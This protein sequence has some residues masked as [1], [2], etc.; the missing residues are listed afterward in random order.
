M[1]MGID[2]V[3]TAAATGIS[4]T[5]TCVKTIQSYRKEGKSLNIERRCS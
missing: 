4:L 2:D 1:A 3:L 5:D